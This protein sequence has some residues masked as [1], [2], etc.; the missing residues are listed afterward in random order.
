M[1]IFWFVSGVVAAWFIP[2]PIS[3]WGRAQIKKIWNKI[4]KKK[5]SIGY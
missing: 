5:E 4:F 1:S 3:A 2:S